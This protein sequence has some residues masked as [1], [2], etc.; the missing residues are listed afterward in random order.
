MKHQIPKCKHPDNPSKLYM[1]NM[2]CNWFWGPF[3]SEE[4]ITEAINILDESDPYWCY[5]PFCILYGADPLPSDYTYGLQPIPLTM[6]ER[7]ENNRHYRIKTN[8]KTT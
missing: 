6:R 2:F 4:H 5:D 8:L 1:Q 3:D 7:I